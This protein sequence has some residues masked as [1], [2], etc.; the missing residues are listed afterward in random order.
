MAIS[1]A[2]SLSEIGLEA[3]G[4]AIPA[5]LGESPDHAATPELLLWSSRRWVALVDRCVA[6]E[7]DKRAAITLTR[8]SAATISGLALAIHGNGRASSIGSVL[9]TR[10]PSIGAF[11]AYINTSDDSRHRVGAMKKQSVFRKDVFA[12]CQA[13][14]RCRNLDL[15]NW[16]M[17]P[18]QHLMRQPLLLRAV[19]EHTDAEHP[20]WP[21]LTAALRK[22]RARELAEISPRSPISKP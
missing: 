19:L 12:E 5:N 18:P 10:A 22:I 7:E 11:Q 2:S 13:D 15:H 6:V 8:K 20:D 21:R 9:E 16:L 17:R 1:H 14:P 4:C 3:D